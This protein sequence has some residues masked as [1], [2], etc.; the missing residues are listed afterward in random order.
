ME[1]DVAPVEIQQTVY[2]YDDGHRLLAG[3]R[4]L[5]ATDAARLLIASDL[6]PGL[7]SVE[8]ISYLTGLPLIEEQSYAMLQTWGAPEISRPGCVW[9]HVLRVP[10]SDM[11]RFTDLSVL[12][13]LFRRPA[14]GEA[15]DSYRV[16][17]NF[18][19]KSAAL[20]STLTLEATD[21]A[22]MLMRAAYGGPSQA[23]L[24]WIPYIEDALFAL[25]SQQWPRLRRHFSFRTA[26]GA[27]GSPRELRFRIQIQPTP[28]RA[29]TKVN[30]SP[31]DWEVTAV[32]DLLS[33]QPSDFRRF[34]WRYGSDILRVSDSFKALTR[35]YMDT[36]MA[37]LEGDAQQNVLN[38]AASAFP[39]ASDARVIKTDLVALARNSYSH[40]PDMDPIGIWKFLVTQK[41]AVDWPVPSWSPDDLIPANLALRPKEVIG[42]AERAL[43]SSALA[44]QQYLR[45]FIAALTTDFFWNL[46][47]AS[48]ELMQ[49]AGIWRPE[50]LDHDKLI[51]LPPSSLMTL[52]ATSSF[53]EQLA[54]KVIT[55][56]ISLD[57][58]AIAR[59]MWNRHR[60]NVI[61]AI[62]EAATAG[63]VADAWMGLIAEHPDSWLGEDVLTMARDRKAV[64][65][66]A[67]W[68]IADSPDVIA[69]GTTPWANVLR[70]NRGGTED[71]ALLSFALVVALNNWDGDSD[72][73]V[74]RAFEVVYEGI[75]Q[76]RI[77]PRIF[78]ALV[79]A[80][81]H[82]P[83]WKEWDNCYRLTLAIAKRVADKHT[84]EEFARGILDKAI[85]RR[86]VRLVKKIKRGDF[87]PGDE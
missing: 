82:A 55:R 34:L 5:H 17:L 21:A 85:K 39:E 73:V 36:R 54:A 2:G 28:L 42:V 15:F 71:L 30:I 70:Q 68:L 61:Q 79:R 49:T 16:G 76:Q 46:M 59:L 57:D 19:P 52:L 29:P 6:A 38:A 72:Y 10:F 84:D 26:V 31:S 63:K 14:L 51:Q 62:L 77:P 4:P 7:A 43:H 3:S 81:P 25:W 41:S 66:I 86:V 67:E 24:P 9:T 65:Q 48:S 60:K 87:E 47:N 35:L 37:R 33:E 44:A 58:R 32:T 78:D 1:G 13:T 64:G 74:A 11:A 69:A 23:P 80:I 75:L 40:L 22:F 56:L 18:A 83:P 45:T 50:L 8:N 27:H 20:N 53:N 12:R